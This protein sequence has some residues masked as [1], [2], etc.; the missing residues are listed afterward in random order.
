MEKTA[1]FAN[2]EQA[3]YWF[4]EQKRHEHL[5]KTSHFEVAKDNIE[6]TRQPT[7]SE[8]LKWCGVYQYP[9]GRDEKAMV[10]GQ[11]TKVFNKLEKRTK[12]ILMLTYLG[13]F[14]TPE[15][16]EKAKRS[17]KVL[18]QKGFRVILN[19][20]YTK[21]KVADMLKINR[22]TV[23]RHFATANNL[24]TDELKKLEFIAD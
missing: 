4:M 14:A 6:T 24:F 23:T 15:L 1:Y 12:V 2:S 10:M 20:R 9:Q 16:Y 5:I 13:D 22:K 21:I 7:L 11:L 8:L 18:K 19:Y 3:L 17:Q